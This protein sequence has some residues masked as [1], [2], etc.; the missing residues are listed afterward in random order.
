MSKGASLGATSGLEEKPG[1]NQLAFSFILSLSL[2]GSFVTKLFPFSIFLNQL[3]LFNFFPPC[4]FFSN[5]EV[6]K[7][8][9][10]A[11]KLI[12]N[13]PITWPHRDCSRKHIMKIQVVAVEESTKCVAMFS[14]SRPT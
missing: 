8:E 1:W 10:S 5:F 7:S 12:S 6:E 13:I 11:E 2:R 9:I 4:F 3:F 14:L